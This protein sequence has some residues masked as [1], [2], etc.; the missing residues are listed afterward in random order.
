MNMIYEWDYD[1]DFEEG[2]K[3]RE[4][5]NI[6]IKERH[7]KIVDAIKVVKSN[8]EELLSLLKI[9]D[10]QISDLDQR[11]KIEREKLFEQLRIL[12]PQLRDLKDNR[13]PYL[14]KL[15]DDSSRQL[16]KCNYWSQQAVNTI[17]SDVIKYMTD[18][19]FFSHYERNKILIDYCKTVPINYVVYMEINDIIDIKKIP[20]DTGIYI[21]KMKSGQ[22]IGKGYVGQSENIG[23]R[24]ENNHHVINKKE[25][26]EIVLVTTCGPDHREPPYLQNT[27]K[28]FVTFLEDY[29]I[30]KLNPDLNIFKR[31][32]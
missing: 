25:K 3:L 31:N 2:Q 6:P 11:Y 27:K 19:N 21:V 24:I 4:Q 8:E 28:F 23:R 15:L 20:G 32:R 13:F 10:N 14:N 22:D 26:F 16:F 5:L 18:N 30:E 29:F 17:R 1:K 12:N 9:V 7:K